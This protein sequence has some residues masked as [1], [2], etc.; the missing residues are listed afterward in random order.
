MLVQEVR[1]LD[2]LIDERGLRLDCHVLAYLS[3]WRQDSRRFALGASWD[4]LSVTSFSVSAPQVG[5]HILHGEEAVRATVAFAAKCDDEFELKRFVGSYM[6][7]E[8][9]GPQ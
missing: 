9:R 2:A 8:L 3:P 7:E 5:W 6:P 1:V 4:L